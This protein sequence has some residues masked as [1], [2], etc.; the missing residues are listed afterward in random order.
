[1]KKVGTESFTD[2]LKVKFQKSKAD[3]PPEHPLYAIEGW[4]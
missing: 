3:F 2:N 4:G 1:M